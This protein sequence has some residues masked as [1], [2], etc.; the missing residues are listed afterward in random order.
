[1]FISETG[2]CVQYGGNE[3]AYIERI[4]AARWTQM[5]RMR[6][7]ETESVCCIY[8]STSVIPEQVPWW[9]KAAQTAASQPLNLINA[10]DFRWSP[11]QR[12][13]HGYREGLNRSICDHGETARP[14]RAP[15]CGWVG[16][17]PFSRT[18]A[19]QPRAVAARRR[20]SL[21]KGSRRAAFSQTGYE[22]KAS[23]CGVVLNDD[24]S[25]LL[26]LR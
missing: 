1:M 10:S 20:R 24:V 8:T 12:P 19:Q 18:V 4:H 17:S 15:T 11:S 7:W 16:G 21:I 25:L 14:S 26:L 6:W 13:T 23:K 2:S 5:H 9:R 22:I 3:H